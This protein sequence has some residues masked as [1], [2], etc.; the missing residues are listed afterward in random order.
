ML[1]L[2]AGKNYQS[3]EVKFFT[4]VQLPYTQYWCLIRMLCLSESVASNSPPRFYVYKT[5]V[6]Q[7]AICLLQMEQL[8][9]EIFLRF[10]YI[11][12]SGC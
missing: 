4:F 2:Y 3:T 8:Q 9:L 5:F 10:C 12:F 7:V 6:I 11:T 1:L